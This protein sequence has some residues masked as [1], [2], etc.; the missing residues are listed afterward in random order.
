MNGKNVNIFHNAMKFSGLHYAQYRLA[1][2]IVSE[3]SNMP[4]KVKKY[5][6]YDSDKKASKTYPALK[7]TR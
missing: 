4:A 1:L 2:Q 3:F 5:L 6:G 7:C